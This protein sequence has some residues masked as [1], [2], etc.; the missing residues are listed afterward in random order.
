[1]KKLYTLIVATLLV[2]GANLTA[3]TL[4]LSQYDET[5]NA[6]STYLHEVK[7]HV[8]VTNNGP[9]ATYHVARLDNGY[10]S[11]ADSNYFCWDLCYGVGTDSSTFGGVT[12]PSGA[13]NTDF[14][15]G[16]YIRGNN[17]TGND[18][19]V[20]RFYNTADANDY[21]DV[22]FQ[23]NV[24]PTISTIEV[25]AK[26]VN[27]F[28]NPASDFINIS[29]QNMSE[30]NVRLMNLAGVTVKSKSF[31]GL[32]EM[33]MD[34]RELP[35]GVYMLQTISNGNLQDTQRIVISR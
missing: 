2:S 9:E 3:Q 22:T 11:I 1:M 30:G 29:L 4:E 13:R 21:L 26:D 10:S 27:V 32:T 28:P 25:D 24:S 15:I 33:R 18:S 6:N 34:I 23:V 12:I 8:T 35:A 14:Y 17:T 19:L 5:T 20:Y 16:V 7:A 31:K